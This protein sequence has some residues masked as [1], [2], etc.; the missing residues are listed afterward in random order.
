MRL[1]PYECIHCKA[2]TREY[3]QVRMKFQQR[4]IENVFGQYHDKETRTVDAGDAYVF[5]CDKCVHDMKIFGK[6]YVRRLICAAALALIA[7]LAAFG[8]LPLW[9]CVIPQAGLLAMVMAG[10]KEYEERARYQNRNNIVS[11]GW[12]KS[13][14]VNVASMNGISTSGFVQ[15]M[16]LLAAFILSTFL[17]GTLLKIICWLLFAVGALTALASLF[18]ML[19]ARGPYREQDREAA[20]RYY[21]LYDEDIVLNEE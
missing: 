20:A 12:T 16:I 5:V 11:T 8:I 6:H 15:A 14:A 3:A 4:V 19:A 7:I 10:P 1:E 2:E 21:L 18:G 17:T 9:L 13:M